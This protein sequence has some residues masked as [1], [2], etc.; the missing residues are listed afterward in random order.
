MPAPDP[1]FDPVVPVNFPGYARPVQGTPWREELTV[2]I[3]LS[4]VISL[5]VGF[6]VAT[7]LHRRGAGDRSHTLEESRKEAL[8]VREQL[9][10]AEAQRDSAVDQLQQ[11]KQ[12][13]ET[14]KDSLKAFSAEQL[15]ENREEFLKHAELRLGKT[16]EKHSSEL[17]KRHEEIEKQFEGVQKKMETFQELHRKIEE[18]RVKDFGSLNQQVLGLA[19]QT[20][21]VEAA[22]NALSTALRG[23]SQSRGKWGEMALR[24][25]VE[26]AGMTEHCD[27]EEQKVDDDTRPDMVVRMPGEGRIPIDAKVPYAEYE[28]AIAA[29]DPAEQKKYFAEHGKVVRNTMLELAKKNYAEKI[30]G[31]VDFTVMFIPVESVAAAAFAARPDLQEEAI[32][33]KILIVTPV[34][35]IALLKTVGIYWQQE[36]LAANAQVIW[37]ETSRLHDRLKTFHGHMKKVGKGLNSALDGFNSAVGSWE[38]SVLPQARSIE[39]LSRKAEL[40]ELER[41]DKLVRDVNSEIAHEALPEPEETL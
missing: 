21:A 40:P 19:E 14:L 7:L 23:S 35:L 15:K 18:Q 39:S 10:R 29:D 24:N 30:D 17:S 22:S 11:L 5:I 41:I 34:T 27:F 37:E 31:D 33:K 2:E 32:E 25:I 20:K 4:V 36:K 26:A 1:L 38:R 16:E 8:D 6:V 13:R 28:R 12:D 9:A 3:V